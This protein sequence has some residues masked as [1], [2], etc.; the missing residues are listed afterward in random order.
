MKNTAGRN[1]VRT[2]FIVI[3]YDDGRKIEVKK[4]VIGSPYAEEIRDRKVKRIDIY[5]G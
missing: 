1:S 3:R 5:L 4:D 2:R